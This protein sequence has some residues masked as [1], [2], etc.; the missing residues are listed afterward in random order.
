MKGRSVFKL[1]AV[2]NAASKDFDG[3]PDTLEH[4]GIV[5]G[6]AS[7]GPNHG[8]WVP[9][10]RPGLCSLRRRAHPHMRV[11]NGYTHTD[12]K[13]PFNTNIALGLIPA[14]EQLS[15]TIMH[16][17][18]WADRSLKAGWIRQFKWPTAPG[19][20]EMDSG[21]ETRTQSS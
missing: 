8:A 17:Q 12:R 2:L 10:R 15:A 13:R 14:R 3:I 7:R 11:H 4:D 6:Q 20:A 1:T 5:W 21:Q 16:S 9:C 18:P 19:A